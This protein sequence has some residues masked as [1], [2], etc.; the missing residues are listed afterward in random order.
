MA[1]ILKPA[2]SQR[3]T[4][5]K[6]RDAP[7]NIVEGAFRDRHYFCSGEAKECS[8]QVQLLPSDVLIC[9]FVLVSF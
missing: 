4:L 9:G 5:F 1:I 8:K 3:R 6:C 7:S 2:K